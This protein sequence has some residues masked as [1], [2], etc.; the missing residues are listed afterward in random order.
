MRF[1]NTAGPI[2]PDDH[3]C[4]PPLG[5]KV[6]YCHRASASGVAIEVWGV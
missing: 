2:R 3:Y 4:I 6:F 1:F 5:R